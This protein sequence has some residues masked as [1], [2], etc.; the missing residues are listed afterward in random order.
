MSK[1]NENLSIRQ[2]KL[3]QALIEYRTPGEAL[4]NTGIAVSTYYRWMSEPVFIQALREQESKGMDE[5]SRRLLAGRES[6]IDTVEGI[7]T[8]GETEAVKLRACQ[9][10]ADLLFKFRD[11]AS[12]EERLTELERIVNDQQQN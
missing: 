2:K 3:I 4:E 11:Q 8:S 6:L 9:I 7:M 5:A 1:E 10:Y 12:I